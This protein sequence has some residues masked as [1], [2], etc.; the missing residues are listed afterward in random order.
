VV[1]KSAAMAGK[2]GKYMSIENGPIADSSPN[3]SMR[4]NLL[5]PFMLGKGGKTMPDSYVYFR[6]SATVIC[7]F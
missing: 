6:K 7:W 1:C 2:P 4:K 3:I 5:L